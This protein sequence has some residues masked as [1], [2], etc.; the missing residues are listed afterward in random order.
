[1]HIGLSRMR[2]VERQ[3]GERLPIAKLLWC[4]DILILSMGQPFTLQITFTEPHVLDQVM[5]VSMGSMEE[6][7]SS[8]ITN[9]YR[10]CIEYRQRKRGVSRSGVLRS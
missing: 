9:G 10:T 8:E 4:S 6:F 2:E 5:P 3:G 7:T 1:M